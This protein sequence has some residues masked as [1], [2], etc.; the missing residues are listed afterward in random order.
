MGNFMTHSRE[1]RTEFGKHS[2]LY[3]AARPSYPT[4]VIDDI[5]TRSSIPTSG[6]VL[7]I[8]CGPGRATLL[9]GERGYRVVG[10]DL[11]P[12]MI[13]L[14]REKSKVLPH[15][16]YIVGE[17]ES[18]PLPSQSF[19]LIIAAQ[20]LHWIDPE[21]G[22]RKMYDVLKDSGM[23]A[24]FWNF[25]NYEQEGFHAKIRDLYIRHCPAFPLDLG[26]Y[27]RY[28]DTLDASNLFD[29]CIVS[30]HYWDHKITKETYLNLARS[31]AWVSSLSDQASQHLLE[32][33]LGV[34]EPEPDTLTIPF[35]TALLTTRKKLNL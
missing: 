23:L 7:D 25:E 14:S 15:I 19:D 27:Q 28:T 16:Y 9:F 5:I 35:K 12:E 6:C 17:F 2:V 1:L 32:G 29:S 18:V 26:S 31:W 10:I 34:L 22:Y 8:G 3:D 30:T 24:A 11:S 13:E 20:A 33:I 4:S 21:Q